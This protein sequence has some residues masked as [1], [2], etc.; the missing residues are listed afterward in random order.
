M[1]NVFIAPIARLSHTGSRIPGELTGGRLPDATLAAVHLRSAS[2]TLLLRSSARP[3][4][5][6]QQSKTKPASTTA[7]AERK[8]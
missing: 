1:D 7:R 6:E 3:M 5:A 4:R 2:A 8:T